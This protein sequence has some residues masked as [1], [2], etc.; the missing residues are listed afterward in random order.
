M[1]MSRKIVKKAV[2]DLRPH[3]LNREL[4]G[5]PSA[6]SAYGDIKRSM[7]GGGYDDR[8]PLL[9]TDD[10]RI[11]WGCTRHAVAKSLGLDEVPCEVFAPPDP[12]TRELEIEAEIIKGNTYRAKDELTIAREQRKLLEVEKQLARARMADGSDGGPSKSTDRV[13]ATFRQSGKTVARRLKVLDAIEAAQAAGDDKKAKQLTDLLN[14]KRVVKALEVIKGK[15]ATP[16]KAP[17]VDVP[18][19]LHSHSTAAYSAFYEA[20]CKAKSPAE[21]DLLAGTLERMAADLKTA[22]ERCAPSTD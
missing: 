1:A 9:V 20:C 5:P 13:G 10:G 3:P 22:R 2:A 16:K 18:K 19:T 7:N 21:C 8:Q 14:S 15:P 12:A 4:Y 6:N 11:I 17:A